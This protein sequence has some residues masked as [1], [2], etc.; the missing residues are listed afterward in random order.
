MAL[1]VFQL[2]F[3]LVMAGVAVNY[4]LSRRRSRSV[5]ETVRTQPV[6][7]GATTVD[8]LLTNDHRTSV[9]ATTTGTAV[10]TTSAAPALNTPLGSPLSTL[11]EKSSPELRPGT[12]ASPLD[13][14]EK[15]DILLSRGVDQRE[16]A[17]QTGLSLAE[18]QLIGKMA[19]KNQ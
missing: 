5:R 15:A 1:W 18:L 16:V 10:A 4:L 3:D 7:V 14:Y 12:Q 2:I 19:Q 11:T 9:P 6:P 17:R 13:A 8:L